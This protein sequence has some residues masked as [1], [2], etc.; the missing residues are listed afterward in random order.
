MARRQITRRAH[1]L[2]LSHSPQMGFTLR[3]CSE[4]TAAIPLHSTPTTASLLTQPLPPSG[5]FWS[6]GP[7]QETGAGRFPR[8]EPQRRMAV[9]PSVEGS[10][11]KLD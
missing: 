1:V 6:L 5:G 4:P 9:E 7:R 11:S 10:Q 3:L 2:P 8:L